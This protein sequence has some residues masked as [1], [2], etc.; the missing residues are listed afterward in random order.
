MRGVRKWIEEILLHA[1]DDKG[2]GEASAKSRLRLRESDSVKKMLDSGGV[3]IGIETGQRR[4][5][6]RR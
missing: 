1:A 2:I 5:G 4:C 6:R 3:C